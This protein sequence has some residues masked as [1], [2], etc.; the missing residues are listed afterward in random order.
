VHGTPGMIGHRR[1]DYC[2]LLV[3][4]TGVVVGRVRE[5]RPHPNAERIRLAAVDLGDGGPPLQIVFGGPPVVAVGDLVPV[6]PPGA[7]LPKGKMRRRRYRGQVSHGMLCSLDELAWTV[8]GPDEVV[9]LRGVAPGDSLDN[10]P[11][12][13]SIVVSPALPLHRS[14]VWAVVPPIG[15]GPAM[16]KL[17]AT[18]PG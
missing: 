15:C 2:A 16:P 11:D 3:T 6:A 1:P 17:A 18:R 10:H 14:V 7:R 12:R 13:Q 5:V 8:G 4:I 9:R